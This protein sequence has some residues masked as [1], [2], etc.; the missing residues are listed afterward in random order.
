MTK[1]HRKAVVFA[2]K[3]LL[4]AALL[5]WLFSQ[6][7]LRDY[8]ETTPAGQE[9]RRPGLLTIAR[10]IDPVWVALAGGLY[11][12]SMVII[13]FR[14]RMLLAIQDVRVRP[15]EAIRLTFLGQF[16]NAIVPGTVG[17]DLVKAYYVSKHTA[18]KAA[19]LVSVFV[20]RVLGL[21]ELTLMAATTTAVVLAAGL[22]TFERL[23]PAV[24]SVAVVAGVT[25][26]M[27]VFV[28]SR[29]FRRLFHLQK[30]YRR[31]PM[32][33]HVEAAGDAAVV[34]GRRL[35]VLLVAVLVTLG[36]HIAFVSTIAALGESLG[37]GVPLYSYF[38]YVPLIYIVG[39]VPLTPGG[40]GLVEGLFVLFLDVPGAGAKVLALAL[41]SRLIPV[42]WGLPGAVV[43]VTGPKLPEA[44]AIEAE[45]GLNDPGGAGPGR[46]V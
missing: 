32:A 38:L 20:D 2:G 9:V 41:L 45:L 37:L 4:A 5:V 42:L 23:R 17:G 1:R 13:A 8:T 34:Y 24:V 21:T 46:S 6:V 3:C 18:K 10:E 19:V 15:W 39:A 30:L 22:E 27:L 25:A 35:G 29:R 33:H 28:L 26:G 14:W 11:L 44:A 36:A 12:A 31:L 16:F 7:H 40:V 43:A